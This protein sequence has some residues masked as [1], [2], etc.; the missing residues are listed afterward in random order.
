[1]GR[2]E[3]GEEEGGV[4]VVGG[5]EVVF[6]GVVGGLGLRLRLMIKI[7]HVESDQSQSGGFS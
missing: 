2:A 6:E 1:M 5:E 7:R 4:W 3:K